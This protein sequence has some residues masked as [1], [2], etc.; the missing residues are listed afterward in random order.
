MKLIP[1]NAF[2]LFFDFQTTSASPTNKETESDSQTPLWH[3]EAKQQTAASKSCYYHPSTS[4]QARSYVILLS[5]VAKS[6]D[7]N[8]LV[9]NLSSGS[10]SDFFSSYIINRK[11]LARTSK[12]LTAYSLTENGKIQ[13]LMIK[14]HNWHHQADIKHGEL[15]AALPGGGQRTAID[16]TMALY[17]DKYC[18]RGIYQRL[19]IAITV[20]YLV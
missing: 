5:T 10:E 14:L 16:E 19:N 13:A 2:I 15:V 17:S 11:E 20:R 4:R 6:I 3:K 1:P 12:N 8:F 9:D 18:F 7:L